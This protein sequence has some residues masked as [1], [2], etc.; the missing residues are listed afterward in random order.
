VTKWIRCRERD[1]SYLRALAT[2]LMLLADTTGAKRLQHL[3]ATL[4]TDLQRPLAPNI[5]DYLD[6][7]L[8][9]S[10]NGVSTP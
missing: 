7:V 6:H 1:P 4:R 3:V 8:A 5:A 9:K 2:F 10:Q